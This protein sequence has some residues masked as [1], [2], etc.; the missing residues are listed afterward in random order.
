MPITDI[1]L[2]S[3]LRPTFFALKWNGDQGVRHFSCNVTLSGGL[4]RFFS[5]QADIIK[6]DNKSAIPPKPHILLNVINPLQW[7]V[8]FNGS[9]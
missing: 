9:I 6:N 4:R 7:A 5:E 2:P 3:W 8:S 1:G